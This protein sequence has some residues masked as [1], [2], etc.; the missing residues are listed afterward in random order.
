MFAPSRHPIVVRYVYY[1]ALLCGADA[2]RVSTAE[3]PF[4]IVTTTALMTDYALAKQMDGMP[5]EMNGL[6]WDCPRDVFLFANLID[7]AIPEIAPN[8][9]ELPTQFTQNGMQPADP[10][11]A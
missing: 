7:V 2:E 8:G 6:T 11:Y 5:P 4:G 1:P 3:F 10:R 9:G